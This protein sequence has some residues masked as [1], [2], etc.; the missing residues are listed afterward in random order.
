[1]GDQG[2]GLVTSQV[3]TVLNSS[4][5]YVHTSVHQE[6]G[7]QGEELVTSQMRPQRGHT[8]AASPVGPSSQ[9]RAA[10]NTRTP[11]WLRDPQGAGLT[12]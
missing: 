5:Q 8:W 10:T 4:Y 7:H 1:M 11:L 12:A 2:E 6:R 3:S 9:S